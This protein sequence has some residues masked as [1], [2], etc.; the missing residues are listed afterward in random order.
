MS[1]EQRGCLRKISPFG[2]NDSSG[3]RMLL[4]HGVRPEFAGQL[5]PF[6]HNA[7]IKTNKKFLRPFPAPKLLPAPHAVPLERLNDLNGAQRLNVLNGLN[8]Y[9]PKLAVRKTL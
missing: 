1:R 8:G 7:P 9:L 5:A 6:L 2:R 4:C 3:I